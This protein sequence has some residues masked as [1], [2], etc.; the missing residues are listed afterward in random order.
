[1]V[2][3][4]SVG[5]VASGCALHTRGPTVALQAT[6]PDFT[7]KSHEGKDVSLQSLL[8]DGP[9][10]LVF[11]RGFW[12]TYCRGQLGE[13][14]KRQGD[15]DQRGASLVAISVDTTEDSVKLASKLGIGFPLL[16]DPGLKAA[17]AYG[18]A[19]QGDEIAV[20]S[21]FVVTQ[22]HK[23]SF[24]KVGESIADRPSPDDILK[25]VDAL[26]K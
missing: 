4:G 24:K 1:M 14:A 15:F 2:A 22:D 6:A 8:R 17:L 10:V 5:L 9:A 20:P 21:T 16:A 12:W 11:Y 13:L 7:L 19:M 26:K 23:I 25:A 3:L 18:V